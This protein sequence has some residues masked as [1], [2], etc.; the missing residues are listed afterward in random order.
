MQSFL[1][2]TLVQFPSKM[3]VPIQF[4]CVS[5]FHRIEDTMTFDSQFF[6][7][8]FLCF[9]NPTFQRGLY[10]LTILLQG[11]F[12]SNLIVNFFLLMKI[13]LI[14]PKLDLAFCSCQGTHGYVVWM[15]A[16]TANVTYSFLL[17]YL[18]SCLPLY[19]AIIILPLFFLTL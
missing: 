14:S 15:R 19:G 12:V 8:I 4:L 5:L 2:V 9:E 13:H 16:H 3:A 11:L 1:Y 17:G 18:Y 7:I 10:I 6:H